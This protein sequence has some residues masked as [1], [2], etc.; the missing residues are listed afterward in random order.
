MQSVETVLSVLSSELA[1]G[2]GYAVRNCLSAGL[3]RSPPA[4]SQHLSTVPSLGTCPHPNHTLAPS[5][6]HRQ[7]SD[8]LLSELIP[9]PSVYTAS[10]VPLA[11]RVAS[12]KHLKRSPTATSSSTQFLLSFSISL[13]GYDTFINI[14]PPSNPRGN[15]CLIQMPCYIL[16]PFAPGPLPGIELLYHA[17]SLEVPCPIHWRWLMGICSVEGIQEVK[18]SP[19]T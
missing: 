13:K 1:L 5:S 15:F 12:V 8:F 17:E 16:K 14:M 2:H 18:N 3:P 7:Q 6:P 9:P 19:R 11:F 10:L 4:P